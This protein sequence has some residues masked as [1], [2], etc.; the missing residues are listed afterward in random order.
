MAKI[1]KP[2]CGSLRNYIENVETHIVGTYEVYPNLKVNTNVIIK[3]IMKEGFNK[4]IKELI[5]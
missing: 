5:L 3:V 4:L 2:P 1:E